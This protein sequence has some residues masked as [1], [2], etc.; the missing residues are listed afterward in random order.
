[1]GKKKQS[2]AT[3]NNNQKAL[4]TNYGTHSDAILKIAN[5]NINV[6]CDDLFGNSPIVIAKDGDIKYVTSKR[7]VDTGLLDPY[8]TYC[9]DKFTI[10]EN[11]DKSNES[12]VSYTIINNITNQTITI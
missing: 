1:M 11:V 3:N 8:K 10:I 6:I 5:I 7:N 12:E 4:T 2:K 9:K